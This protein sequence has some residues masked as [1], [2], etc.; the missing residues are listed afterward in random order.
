MKL[1]KALM[2]ALALT[3]LAAPLAAGEVRA[4]ATTASL[5][6]TGAPVLTVTGKLKSGAQ[7]DLTMAELRALPRAQIK[8][9]TPWHDG[10][11]TFEGVP[12]AALLEHLGAQGKM[13]QVMALNKYKTEIPVSDVSHAPI[14]AYMRNGEPMSVR[15]KG[16]LFVI[17]PYDRNPE[18][19]SERYFSRSAWQV[20]SI[21]ID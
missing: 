19:K 2:F 6:Q 16:P 14:L 9:T 17:Y 8:T 13:L 3:T 20:R 4:Q 11:Q 15:D 7:I 21:A 18:L 12:L 10:E 5:P 1:N